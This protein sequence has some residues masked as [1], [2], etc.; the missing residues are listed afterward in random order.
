M[1]PTDPDPREMMRP[2]GRGA[3]PVAAQPPRAGSLASLLSEE[4]AQL[5]SV[6]PVF[7]A[8]IDR[9]AEIHASNQIHEPL[10]PAH[11]RLTKRPGVEIAARAPEDSLSATLVAEAKYA[12]PEMFQER[13]GVLKT[14]SPEWRTA[15]DIYV[16]GFMFYEI[17]L[18]RRLF[19]RA[20]AGVP[21]DGT[22]IAWLSWHCD[23]ERRPPPLKT[24]IAHFYVPLSDTVDQ[25]LEKDPARRLKGLGEAR[26]ALE[27]TKKRMDQTQAVP[28][29]VTPPT[30][31]PAAPRPSRKKRVLFAAL[32]GIGLL[33]ASGTGLVLWRER[34]SAPARTELRPPSQEARKQVSAKTKTAQQKPAAVTPAPSRPT[35]APAASAPALPEPV[36]VEPEPSAAREPE[37]AAAL[38]PEP[39]AARKPEPAEPSRQLAPVAKLSRQVGM[40]GWE[41]PGGW[42]RAADW[43]VRRGGE[44]VPF[45]VTPTA[46]TFV[47]TARLRHGK[48]LQ[49]FLRYA[50]SRNYVLCQMDRKTFHRRLIAGGRMTELAKVSHGLPDRAVLEATIQIDISPSSVD[51]SIRKGNDWIVLDSWDDPNG[52]FDKGKFGFLIPGQDEYGILHFAFHAR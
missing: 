17:F 3:P 46:G 52:G 14:G 23:V 4:P 50:D 45:Q 20:L 22:D 16:L 9:I 27:Q 44:F 31:A 42:V 51:H 2:P 35:A 11:V 33:A 28:V 34:R 21:E 43:Y 25:M 29:M 15:S 37:P 10:C 39:S 49:W 6:I 41:D 36:A 7:L 5:A 19:R 38:E 32:L 24:L 12:A 1:K 26:K 18:G 40:A 13:G 8:I 48:R 30:P 47:F